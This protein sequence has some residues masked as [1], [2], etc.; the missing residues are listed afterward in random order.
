MMKP[1]AK[2]EGRQ[3]PG[4]GNI[5]VDQTLEEQSVTGQFDQLGFIQ[6]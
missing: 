3:A 6:F 5:A 4:Q 1:L 2:E